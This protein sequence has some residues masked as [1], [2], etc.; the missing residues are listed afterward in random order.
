MQ[1]RSQRNGFLQEGLVQIAL[2][3]L[4]VQTGHQLRPLIPRP[5]AST[6][7]RSPSCCGEDVGELLRDAGQDAR[8]APIGRRRSAICVVLERAGDAR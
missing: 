1:N 7:R 6:A 3:I 4:R 5:F 2:G 8:L